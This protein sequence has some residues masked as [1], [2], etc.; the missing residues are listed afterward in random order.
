MRVGVLRLEPGR[1]AVLD[2]RTE[3]A[4]AVAEEEVVTVLIPARDEERFI[5]ACLESVLSQTERDLQVIVVDGASGDRTREIVRWHAERDPRVELLVNAEGGGIPTSLN[6]G[7][8]AARG[9]W[10][11]RVDAHATIPP[12]YVRRVVSH[13]ATGRWGGVGGRKDGVGETPT[14]RAIA[15]ALAS[16]FGVGN[17]TYH[18]GTKLQSVDHVPFGAYPTGLLRE[19]GGW[20]ERLSANED[21]ELDYRLRRKGHQLLFDPRVAIAWRCR[22]RIPDLFRQ[23]RRYGRGKAAVV[24]VHPESVRLR[25]LAAPALIAGWAV[26]L[27]L[28][29]RWKLPL[30]LAVVPYLLALGAAALMTARKAGDLRTTP[31]IAAAFAAMHVAWGLGFWEGLVKQAWM[32]CTG[33][34]RR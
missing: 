4:A 33:K 10:L 28:S 20:D 31:R 19:I 7:L 24:R 21:Y 15:A 22:Q 23:Y 17:S 34:G 2:L 32:L 27:A 26:A 1:E 12:E 13:L 3:G 14:G 9:R 5:G 25:H 30:A 8:R 16:P 6:A 29:F 18:H 11:V